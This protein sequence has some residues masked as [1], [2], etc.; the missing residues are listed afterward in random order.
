VSFIFS[1]ADVSHFI[2]FTSLVAQLPKK[3]HIIGIFS[4]LIICSDY[5]I[6]HLIAVY[7]IYICDVGLEDVEYNILDSTI[8]DPII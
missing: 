3:E 2:G 5:L 6:Q 1:R 8:I 7:D 4:A